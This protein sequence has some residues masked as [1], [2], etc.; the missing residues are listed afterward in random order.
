M[1]YA[2]TALVGRFRSTLAFFLARDG[3]MK[4]LHP[5][6][7]SHW[8][9]GGNYFNLIDPGSR[10]VIRF[11]ANRCVVRVE[12]QESVEPFEK[13]VAMALGMFDRFEV[14][15]IFGM[16][17]EAIQ[18][19]PIRRLQQARDIFAHKFILERISKVFPKDEHTDYGISLERKE[20]VDINFGPSGAKL[21]RRALISN[22][23]V[24]LGPVSGSE[25]Q[26][27][28][29]E[30]KE[31]SNNELYQTKP[32]VPEAAHIVWS[33]ITIQPKK[34]VKQISFDTLKRFCPWAINQIHKTW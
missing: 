24:F 30:F 25:L 19:Q 2:L 31:K 20:Q 3:A 29:L 9:R 33:Q 10:R 21:S 17:F 13:C 34:G 26:E 1:R 4:D 22:H 15:D 11:D 8:M 5:N 23:L 12:G 14:S 7:F 27:R 32:R 16:K 6:E 18:V 28:W